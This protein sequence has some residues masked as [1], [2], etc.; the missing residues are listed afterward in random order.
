MSSIHDNLI[1]MS[2]TILIVFLI[3]LDSDYVHESS[4]LLMNYIR[5]INK[6]IAF[7]SKLIY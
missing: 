7:L 1:Y 2:I 4:T 6:K 5:S 3:S